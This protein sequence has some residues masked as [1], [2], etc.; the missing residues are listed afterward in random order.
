MCNECRHIMATGAKCHA[1]ALRDKPYCY[2]HI[3][4]HGFPKRPAPRPKTIK[5]PV[6][7]NRTAIQIALTK[8]LD[9]LGSAQI[10][11]HRA[12]LILYTIQLASQNPDLDA[13]I[14]PGTAVQSIVQAPGGNRQMWKTVPDGLFPS[15]VD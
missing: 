14:V 9:G 3:R 8:V 4:L 6:P 5:F 10:D 11:P 2:F 12:G 7:S 13:D 1:P 15:G